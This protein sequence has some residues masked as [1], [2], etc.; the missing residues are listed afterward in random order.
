MTENMC[1][2]PPVHRETEES[3]H[4]MPAEKSLFPQRWCGR[5]VPPNLEAIWE[6]SIQGYPRGAPLKW[7]ATLLDGPRTAESDA[8]Q[9]PDMECRWTSWYRWSQQILHS[10]EFGFHRRKNAV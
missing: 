8:V 7:H 6:M 3:G 2:W 10:Q 5:I 9:A 4:R 1:K